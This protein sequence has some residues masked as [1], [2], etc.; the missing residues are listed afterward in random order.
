MSSQTHIFQST[1]KRITLVSIGIL[2]TALPYFFSMAWP[3]VIFKLFNKATWGE[4][5]DTLL[6]VNLISLILGWGTKKH[7]LK[8]FDL[9]PG[10]ISD[11]WLENTHSRALL[12]LPFFFFILI[13]PFS[14]VMKA[15]ILLLLIGKFTYESYEPLIEYKDKYTEAIVAEIIGFAAGFSLVIFMMDTINFEW[16]IFSMGMGELFRALSLVV[17]IREVKYKLSI[18]YVN[19]NFFIQAYPFFMIGFSTL[20]MFIADRV[21]V[22]INFNNII[23]AEY[24]IFMNFLIFVI[25]VPNLLLI[26]FF[27]NYYKSRIKINQ[28][29]QMTIILFGVILTPVIIYTV[30]ILC[31]YIYSID[32]P[33][34]F[35]AAGMLYI[36]PSFVYTPYIL[37][38]T[39]KNRH[40][41]IASVTF[42][43]AI[44]VGLAC[45]YL[46][47]IKGVNGALMGAAIG[48]WILMAMII[49]MDF[50]NLSEKKI[51]LIK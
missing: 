3:F 5:V 39:N 51:K 40:L 6:I 35:I 7:M 25:S 26:P 48:Q 13:S 19:L 47:R 50:Q 27:K 20:L 10:R 11:S 32:I 23:K 41:Y 28:Y 18:R 2:R 17:S 15:G 37:K 36:F 46:V 38:L 29:L 8:K 33:F 42:I 49:I 34:S 12:F 30:S 1:Q 31:H 45:S 9:M 24:Q 21:F 22:Y 4:C 14:W 44:T 43:A 16:I